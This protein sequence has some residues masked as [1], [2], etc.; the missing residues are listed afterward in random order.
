MGGAADV[1]HCGGEDGPAV[2]AVSLWV[3]LEPGSW[4]PCPFSEPELAIYGEAAG[5]R[6]V[7]ARLRHPAP[8]DGAD[9]GMPWVFR[10]T[11]TD[12]AAHVNNAV[13][14]EPLEEELLLAGADPEQLDVEIEY[15]NAAQ[16]GPAQVL[17]D[18][19]YRWIVGA[20]REPYASIAL[21]R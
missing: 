20:E 5:G 13:Y 10:A 14:W 21:A 8:P 4:R 6:K 1:G 19:R 18:G 17:S 9:P 2:E 12:L 3:H 16:P 7:T 11:D 15:R